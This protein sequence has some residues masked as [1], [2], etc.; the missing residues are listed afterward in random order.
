MNKN[1]TLLSF[2]FQEFVF[3]N[4]ITQESVPNVHLYISKYNSA[5]KQLPK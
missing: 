4:K 5:D 3:G 2:A 1:L